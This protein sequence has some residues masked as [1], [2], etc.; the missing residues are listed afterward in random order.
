MARFKVIKS[1]LRLPHVVFEVQM[2]SGSLAIGQA[3]S[4]WA[5]SHRFDF[6]VT[7]V[8]PSEETTNLVC[9]SGF[10]ERFTPKDRWGDCFATKEV[11]TDDPTVAQGC[12]HR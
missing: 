7:A 10:L 2:V 6:E 12:S 11:D 4:L 1:S 8:E 3:F 9:T 5:T